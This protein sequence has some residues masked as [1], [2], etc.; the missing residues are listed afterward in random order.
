M[1]LVRRAHLLASLRPGGLNT[2]QAD[3]P[4]AETHKSAILHVGDCHVRQTG[5]ISLAKLP[6]GGRRT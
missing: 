3:Q 6:T 2:S 4:D 5:G 1:L